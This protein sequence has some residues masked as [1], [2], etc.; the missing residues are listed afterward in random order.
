[1]AFNLLFPIGFLTVAIVDDLCFKKFHN[2]LFLTLSG[3]G[4]S[5]VFLSG[6][7]NPTEAFLGFLTGG[8][9]MLPLVF[10]GAV[11]AGDMKFMMSFGILT[12]TA[13]IFEIFIYSLFWGGLFGLFQ[14]FFAGKISVVIQNLLGFFYKLKPTETQKIPYTIAIFF[15]WI[16]HNSCGGLF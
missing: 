14:S 3:M 2:W 10:M 13:L 12:G 8:V 9:L 7:V 6:S 5:F 16:T 4:F 1:M 15:G 11:G